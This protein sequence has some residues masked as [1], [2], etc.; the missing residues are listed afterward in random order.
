MVRVESLAKTYQG[1]R[2]SPPV[3]AVDGV[4]FQVPPGQLLG[5]LGP[6][7]AGKTTTV[8]MMCGLIRPD[9]GQILIN[10]TDMVRRRNQALAHVSAVLE[11][12]RNIYWRLSCRENLEFFAGLKGR[13]PRDVRSEIDYY[14]ELFKLTEKVNTEARQLSRG[15]QQKLAIA[16]ALISQSEVLLLDEPTLGLDVQASFEIR[17]LLKRMVE[18]QG[19]TIIL[20]THDMNVVQ[21]TCKRVIIINQGRIVSD[22]SVHN[23]LDLFKVKVYR[24]VIDGKLTPGQRE[25]LENLPEVLLEEENPHETVI[26]VRLEESQVLYQVF[27]ILGAENTVIHSIDQE[28]NN[29]ERVFLEIL[30]RGDQSA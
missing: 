12:N 19:R 7:G 27:G 3:K 26:S 5:L 30:E 15:M 21:D 1:R 22:D 23:L 24:I 2:G 11:G 18:E 16:V 9:A 14:L 10:G 4:S 20:T 6:N 13:S 29:F 28:Q 8:K 17:E 25:A